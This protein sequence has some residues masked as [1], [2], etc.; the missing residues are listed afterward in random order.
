MW[1]IE[2][3]RGDLIIVMQRSFANAHHSGKLTYTVHVHHLYS[4]FKP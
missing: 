2:E 1:K 3:S 4:N